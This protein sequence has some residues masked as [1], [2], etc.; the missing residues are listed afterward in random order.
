MPSEFAKETAEKVNNT[1]T[2]IN[3]EFFWVISEDIENKPYDKR[4]KSFLKKMYEKR[5]SDSSITGEK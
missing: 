1:D 5:N 2:E 4:Y 3:P